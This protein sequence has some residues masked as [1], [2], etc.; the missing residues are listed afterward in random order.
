MALARAVNWQSISDEDLN[1]LEKC[2][3]NEKSRREGQREAT[4]KSEDMEILLKVWPNLRSSG[5]IK[6]SRLSDREILLMLEPTIKIDGADEPPHYI[7]L[8]KYEYDNKEKYSL[9]ID[10][11]CANG[12]T[13]TSRL[14]F[15]FGAN[16]N[17][18]MGKHWQFSNYAELPPEVLTI[19]IIRDM[20][21]YPKQI[22]DTYLNHKPTPQR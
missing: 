17:D 13:S 22:F 21:N 15:N 2:V 16:K 7:R 14:V 1:E 4:R 5:K 8:E 18:T 11:N 19:P 6:L 10:L 3:K 9:H 12:C 20:F